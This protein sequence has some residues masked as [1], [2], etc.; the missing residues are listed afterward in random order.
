VSDAHVEAQEQWS[1]FDPSKHPG[2]YAEA[3]AKLEV[4]RLRGRLAS[5]LEC[6][7]TYLNANRTQHPAK[8]LEEIVELP[9]KSLDENLVIKY[10]QETTPGLEWEDVGP[11]KPE[12][13]MEIHNEALATALQTRIHFSVEDLNDLNAID[14]SYDLYIKAGYKYFKPAMSEAVKLYG[15]LELSSSFASGCKLFRFMRLVKMESRPQC[16]WSGPTRI[17]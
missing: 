13:G 4:D 12:T 11:R 2:Y 7:T 5:S 9:V 16:C 1:K 3:L 8:Q 15:T 17:R 10:M 14:L 6:I